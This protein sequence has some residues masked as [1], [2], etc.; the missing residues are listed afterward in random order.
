MRTHI[1]LLWR[2]KKNIDL[3]TLFNEVMY[4]NNNNNNNNN[5]VFICYCS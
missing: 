1:I 3:F 4:N 2:N 5:T